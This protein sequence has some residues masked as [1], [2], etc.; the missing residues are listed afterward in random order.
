VRPERTAD[1][2]RRLRDDA[3]LRAEVEHLAPVIA[4][5]ERLSRDAWRAEDPPPLEVG[6]P[7]PARPRRRT[8]VVLRPAAALVASVAFVAAGIAGGIALVGSEADEEVAVRLAPL[9]AT[10]PGGA[11]IGIERGRAVM[12]GDEMR[13]SVR[14]VTPDDEAHFHEV[15]LLPAEGEPV[16]V[17]RFRVA[18]DGHAEA[19]FRLPAGA[20]R[21]AY[22]DVSVEE[23]DGDAG[24]SGRSVLRAPV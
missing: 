12:T 6:A 10:A 17:G 18:A 21:Y 15:W 16:P 22:L 19:T 20:D 7:A 2:A 4:R 1:V 23:A 11:A 9:R 13:V 8:T 14:A 3:R 5:L 24:H